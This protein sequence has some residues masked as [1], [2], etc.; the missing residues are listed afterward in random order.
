MPTSEALPPCQRL[1]QLDRARARMTAPSSKTRLRHATVRRA[2][3]SLTLTGKSVIA[4]HDRTCV[5]DRV[6]TQH[7]RPHQRRLASLAAP[8]K[9]PISAGHPRQPPHRLRTRPD[10][11]ACRRARTRACAPIDT[12]AK[13]SLDRQ[14]RILSTSMGLYVERPGETITRPRRHSPQCQWPPLADQ[15]DGRW[16]HGAHARP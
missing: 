10:P 9:D 5:R 3:R 12:G 14:S 6:H 15:R 4:Y 1:C 2:T 16:R 11:C 7:P 13:F 8:S